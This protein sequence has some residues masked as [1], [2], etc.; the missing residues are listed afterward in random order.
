LPVAVAL[1]SVS[2]VGDSLQSLPVDDVEEQPGYD[3]VG[4]RC[5]PLRIAWLGNFPNN[6]YDGAILEQ[7]TI[8]AEAN[9]A[10]VVPYYGEFNPALQL[11]QCYDVVNSGEFDAM[12]LI[13]TDSV[14]IIP[15][16]EQ[17]KKK[18]VPV[19]AVNLPI[20]PDFSTVE[21]QVRGQVGAVLTPAAK[22]GKSLAALLVESCSADETC[23]VGYIAGSFDVAFDKFALDELAAV[24]AT[25][26]N[27][28]L[29]AVEQAFYDETIGFGLAQAMLTSNP[30]LDVM[31]GAGD[32]MAKAIEDAMAV[33]PSAPADLKIIGAGG[34]AYA[35]QAVREGRWLGTFV[36]LPGD[37]GRLGAEIVFKEL[38]RPRARDRG[39][40]P[41]E[42]RGWPAFFTTENQDEFVG[43]VPQSP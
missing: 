33:V 31:I 36:T 32:Q 38:N 30:D 41:V 9:H 39:I 35:V 19:V 24:V 4:K 34:G 14:G 6:E 18:K 5:R 7:A 13:A 42:A 37:E 8:V 1:S 16:V 15:C 3:P 17:A 25:H 20:G 26:P 10:T 29:V 21:P 40:D 2:Q 43:F 22:F 28:E 11:S 23:N 27:I 12:M